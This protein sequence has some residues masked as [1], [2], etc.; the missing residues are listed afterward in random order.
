MVDGHSWEAGPRL[1]L[2]ATC[3]A[4]DGACFVWSAQK[5]MLFVSVAEEQAVD[6]YNRPIECTLSAT[7]DQAKQLREWLNKNLPD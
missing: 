4:E 5:Q 1:V 7:L 2:E 3:S 6:S